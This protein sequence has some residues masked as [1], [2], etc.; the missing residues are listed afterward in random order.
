MTDLDLIPHEDRRRHPRVTEPHT[1]R[2]HSLD[3]QKSG[4]WDI[5]LSKNLSAGGVLFNYPQA[6]EPETL[7]SFKINTHV[8]EKPAECAGKVRRTELIN[9]ALKM[10]HIAVEF[11]DKEKSLSFLSD[12]RP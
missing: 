3:P 5:V 4:D 6:I 7:L 2:F 8:G 1:V 11:F 10:F 9:P 12:V